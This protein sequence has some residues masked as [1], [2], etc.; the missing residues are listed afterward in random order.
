[1]T[2]SVLQ[3]NISP[4][5]IP[6]RQIPE[7]VITPEGIRGDGWSH[8]DIHGGPNQALLLITSEGI[9]ELVAQGFPVYP[10]ALGENLTTVGLD[11]RQMRAGQ[12]YRAGD[13]FFELTKQRAPCVTLN[14]YGP[15]IQHAIFDAQ[16]NAGDPSTSRWGLSGFY[17]RV[18]IAGTI[19]TQDP[20]QLIDQMV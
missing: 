18:L 19:R 10:G 2:G 20:I 15:G 6:K 11:R 17:A 4:G 9:D 13:V 8:P 3:I 16:V 5:G 12:R 14:V 1:M 7:A